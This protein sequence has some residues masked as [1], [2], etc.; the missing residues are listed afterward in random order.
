MAR[1]VCK[2]N[3]TRELVSIQ[4]AFQIALQHHQAGRL[5][6]AEAI[7]RQILTA[8]P[9]HAD[10][11][12]M[13]GV[14]AGQTGRSELA[15]DLI[16][17][18]IAFAPGVAD[19]HSNLGEAYRASGKLDEA[20]AAYR[21]AIALRPDL[22]EAHSNLG[23]ALWENGQADAAIAACRQ[24]IALQPHFPEA[25]S[26][27]GT[28]LDHCGR[29]DEAIAAYRQAIALQPNF[30][31][32]HSNLGAAL[33]DK[34]RLDEAIAA[35]RQAIALQPDLPGAHS[36][37]GAALIDKGCPAEAFAAYRQAI[38]L[39]PDF[40]EAHSNLG[41]ALTHAAQLDEAIA[42]CRRAI[43]LQP[44]LASA[45]NNLGNAFKGEGQLDEAIACYRHAMTCGP[46]DT[47]H[48]SNLNYALHFHPGCD[49]DS[50]REEH[51]RWDRQFGEPLRK[52]HRPHANDRDP[53]RRLRIGYVSPDFNRH[54]ICH[55]LAPL[56]ESHD[57]AAFEIF[58]YASVKRPDAITQRMRKCADVWRDVLGVRDDALAE[59]IRAD[60]IDILVD[61]TQHMADNRLLTFAR[62][63]APVQV[64]WLGYPSTTGLSA[65]D[66]RLT[67]AHMEPEG[68]PWAESVET[69]LRLPDS[70]FCFDPIDE[71][72]E[73]SPLPALQAG[74]VTFCSLNNFCKINDAVLQ[75]WADVL[76]AVEGSRLLMQCPQGET[77]ARV[78]QWFET[79]GIAAHRIELIAR[80]ATRAE[81]LRLFE[82][83]DLALETFPYNG[84]TTT[85]EALWMGIPVPT[86]PG[87]SAVSRIGLSILSA[88]GLQELIATSPADYVRLTASLAADLPRLA[89]LRA[90]LRTR[91]QSSAFMDAPRFARNV[92]SAYRQMW[93]AWCGQQS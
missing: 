88:T 61:L 91:M 6:E 41:D 5:A 43:A 67:D 72:P 56:I 3:L 89:A 37:L 4:Q 38:A 33:Y 7:Y 26:N 82:R 81:F 65:M 90:T 52:F 17:Q 85:C 64:A 8:A 2:A 51:R 36:N 39:R 35:Y 74:H 58:C 18:A 48:H 69:P 87:S 19:F 28:A 40:A 79:H 44:N 77:Q 53:L 46:N 1:V 78:R 23:N 14:I 20:I 70:W 42:A 12:H 57:H 54:V 13:L 27:L 73:P 63:P 9:Q 68:A 31:K 83:I 49:A 45:H 71:Y 29:S 75:L 55:F 59:Q 92:E 11:L 25:F 16:R 34:G 21:R 50:I 80:T 76:R 93:R 32:A 84:G 47:A 10:A 30:P 62:K 66:Y 60:Q 24:A 15:V 86:F 22:A